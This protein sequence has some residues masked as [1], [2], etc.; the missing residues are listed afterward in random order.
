M[1]CLYQTIL[2]IIQCNDYSIV[3][4]GTNRNYPL[5]CAGIEVIQPADEGLNV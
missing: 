1:E 2:N 5:I 4:L 3:Q